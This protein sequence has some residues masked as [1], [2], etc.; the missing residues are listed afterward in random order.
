MMLIKLKNHITRFGSMRKIVQMIFLIT[1]IVI[2]Y[3]F[4]S[5]T[6]M[7]QAGVIPDLDRPPG[8]EAFLPISAL[9]S[10]KYFFQTGIINDIHP[11][12]LMIFLFIIVL[13][14]LIK[15]SFCSYVCPIGFL[16]EILIKIHLKIFKNGLRV[17]KFIDYP[18]R[19][20]KY[21]L[22]M[23]FGHAIFIQMSGDAIK[24][25]LYSPYNKIADIKMLLF[26]SDISLTAAIIIALLM[27]FSIFIRNFWC[28]YLCPYG[29][30]LGFLSFLSPFKVRRDKDTCLECGKCDQVCPSS[31]HISMTVNITSDECFACGKCIDIC[32]AD[33]T[34][35]LS[36]PGK[37]I[38]L[39]PVIICI[40]VIFIFSGGDLLARFTGNWQNAISKKDYMNNMLEN[41]LININN[42]KNIEKFNE[43]LD[44]RR[45]RLLQYI[46]RE[47]LKN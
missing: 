45:K 21:G 17:N 15:K 2:G 19:L 34:L 14:L 46:I 35:S 16:S 32:P 8:V 39:K 10:L 1:V 29:A 47:Q 30:L 5:F 4:Y 20:I 27:V 13:S 7:L 23:F 12:G 43:N 6:A 37:K 24:G 9:I 40:I 33:K 41:R 25:F 11:S 22:L 3:R 44:R 38:I 31:I 36:L 42:V 18:F 26:F 28:R